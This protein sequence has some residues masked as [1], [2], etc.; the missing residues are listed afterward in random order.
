MHVYTLMYIHMHAHTEDLSNSCNIQLIYHTI[1]TFIYLRTYVHVCT[2]VN[3]TYTDV[4]FRV[5]IRTTELLYGLYTL[6]LTP[7]SVSNST[8]DL[9]MRRENSSSLVTLLRC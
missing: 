9:L 4:H 8:S 6:L 2:H 1:T 3:Y 7:T 5:Y